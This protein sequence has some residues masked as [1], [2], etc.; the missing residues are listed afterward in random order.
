MFFRFTFDDACFNFI[1][2]DF[3]DGFIIHRCIQVLFRNASAGRAAKLDG[4]EFFLAGDAASDII[5]NLSQGCNHGHFYQPDV[6]HIAGKGKDLGSFAALG[7][8]TGI[9]IT[10]V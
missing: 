1:S 9:P 10:P 3:G 7:S 2:V 4:L 5:Y 8:D 6:I